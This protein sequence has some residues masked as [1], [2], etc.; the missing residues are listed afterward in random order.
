ME[1]EEVFLLPVPVHPG[2]QLLQSPV[3]A[4]GAQALR[5]LLGE[6]L[7]LVWL[8]RRWVAQ[9]WVIT[10]LSMA[11]MQLWMLLVTALLLLWR[12][13]AILPW[14]QANSWWTQGSQWAT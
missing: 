3:V 2:R 10:S 13:L 12:L 9:F 4:D 11:W 8:V 5:L 7:L 1:V 6:L 14:M